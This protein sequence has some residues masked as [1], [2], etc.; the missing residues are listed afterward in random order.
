MKLLPLLL[1]SLA[2]ASTAAQTNQIAIPPKAERG[3][4]DADCRVPETG[5]AF[6]VE[7]K[8]LKDRT[9]G[10]VLE[11]Y[12]ATDADFLAPDKKL[13]AAG[14]PFRRVPVTVPA[15]GPI[16]LCIRAPASG[17]YAVSLLHD[18]DR[19]GKFGFLKDGIGFSGNPKLGMQ[20]PTAASASAQV[21]NTVE[22]LQIV[23]NYRQGFSMKP[24]QLAE[25]DQRP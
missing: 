24:L 7:V 3:R 2:F 15:H 17:R 20:K 22:T 13:I 23:M 14:K 12:P 9:G 4:A 10:L 1:T 19:N 16:T 8:G 21:G 6:R 25:R 5:P 11:L 18:R